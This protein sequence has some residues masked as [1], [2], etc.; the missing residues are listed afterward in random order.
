MLHQFVFVV[1]VTADAGFDMTPK[2]PSSCPGP[3]SAFGASNI[4][5]A[6]DTSSGLFLLFITRYSK[7]ITMPIGSY[8]LRHF[9]G[10]V[11]DS[12]RS[13]CN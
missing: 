12:D 9:L 10:S 2:V 6:L 5:N 3:L 11:P 13:L 1:F 4:Q 7:H 8:S